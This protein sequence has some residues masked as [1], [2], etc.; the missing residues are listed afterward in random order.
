MSCGK[1]VTRFVEQARARFRPNS[2]RCAHSASTLSRQRLE[3]RRSGRTEPRP[4]GSQL[5]FTPFASCAGSRALATC[6][7]RFRGDPRRPEKQ[8]RSGYSSQRGI[9]GMLRILQTLRTQPPPARGKQKQKSGPQWPV[10]PPHI[11]SDDSGGPRA[12]TMPIGLRRS[13]HQCGAT[14]TLVTAPPVAKVMVQTSLQ[15]SGARAPGLSIVRGI[16]RD[17]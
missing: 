10:A 11:F 17:G 7:R 8:T 16:L 2:T 12:A 15:L 14:Q 4:S 3:R 1:T 5:V 13:S 6:V 9:Y